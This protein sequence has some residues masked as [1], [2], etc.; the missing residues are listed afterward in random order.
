MPG[1]TWRREVLETLKAMYGE[2]LHA[3]IVFGS[4]VYRGEGRDIDILV[5]VEDYLWDPLTD[6]LEVRRRLRR[7]K[8]PLDV[9]VM[10]LH[11]FEENMRAPSFLYGLALGFE[12]VYWTQRARQLIEELLKRVAEDGDAVLYNRYGRWRLDIHAKRRLSLLAL[13][14][15]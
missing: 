8:A 3:V 4:T 12:P 1:D 2:K 14:Q 6:A 5:L 10:S 13:E 15:R 7:L 9:H 11:D